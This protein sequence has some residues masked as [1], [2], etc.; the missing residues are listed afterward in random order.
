M[1]TA[2][3][4]KIIAESTKTDNTDGEKWC[5]K[6]N[7][8]FFIK[9]INHIKQTMKDFEG[10][11]DKKFITFHNFLT[12]SKNYM[13]FYFCCKKIKGKESVQMIKI[14]KTSNSFSKTKFITYKDIFNAIISLIGIAIASL[15][16]IEI[17]AN[18]K[19]QDYRFII[20]NVI[21]CLVIISINIYAIINRKKEIKE[22]KYIEQL[23][24]RNK[25]LIEVNDNVR[26]FKHDFNN[27]LQAINGYIDLQDMES[28]KKYFN[29][30]IKESHHINIIEVLNFQVMD[31]P[32]IYSVLLSKYKTAKEKDIT[33]NIEIMLKLDR[34]TEKSYVMSRVLGILL[35]NAIESAEECE[36]KLINIRFLKDEKRQKD[37]VLIE[38]TYTNKEID[39]TKIFEKNYTTKKGNSGLGLWKVSD[40][41]EKDSQ[42]E[43]FTYKND[44]MFEQKLEF[45]HKN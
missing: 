32:A 25:N 17:R 37:V 41:L 26:S 33:M 16:I 4:K 15:E 30:L 12:Q 29:S 24:E 6:K 38:N 19:I 10:N 1:Q 8:R 23:E 22:K 21:I 45:Y 27:I 3:A 13:V 42:L 34:F 7:I 36:E 28:L 31:N 40:I 20:Y 39:T 18:F 2:T 43:L 14:E 11:V 44:E 35:D 9:K 5:S